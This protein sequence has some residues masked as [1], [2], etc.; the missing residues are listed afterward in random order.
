M[1]RQLKG[2]Q[3]A[4]VPAKELRVG[5]KFGAGIYGIA[6]VPARELRVEGKLGRQRLPDHPGVPPDAAGRPRTPGYPE[7]GAPP[8][9]IDSWASPGGVRG[10]KIAWP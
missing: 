4:A 10:G 3:N 6:V 2:L 9:G 1:R 8:P 5:S 7:R